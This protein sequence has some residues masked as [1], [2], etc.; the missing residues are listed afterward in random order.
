[1]GLGWLLGII[2]YLKYCTKGTRTAFGYCLL[3][4]MMFLRDWSRLRINPV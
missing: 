3:A 4:E 2:L 1:M